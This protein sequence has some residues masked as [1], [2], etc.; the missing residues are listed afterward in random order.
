MQLSGFTGS[1]GKLR[2]LSEV[3]HTHCHVWFSTER[4]RTVMK[5]VYTQLSTQDWMHA[6][7]PPWVKENLQLPGAAFS[8]PQWGAYQLH[9]SPTYFVL[10]IHRMHEKWVGSVILVS[11]KALFHVKKWLICHFTL[12]KA[13]KAKW[14]GLGG[15]GGRRAVTHEKRL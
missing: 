15:R 7:T 9:G 11:I 3:W 1:V 13:W 2:F 5:M 10:Q 14:R 12:K 4:K 6:Q 8:V